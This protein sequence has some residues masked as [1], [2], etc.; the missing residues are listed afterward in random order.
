MNAVSLVPDDFRQL[1]AAVRGRVLVP[2]A[3]GYEEARRVVN[4]MIDRRPAAIVRCAGV[5]DIKSALAHGIDRN[6]PISIRCGGHSVPGFAVCEG[7]IMIDLSTMNSVR[8]DPAA[9]RARC[10]GGTNW[11]KFD[12]ETQAFG[13]ATTGG[14]VR[15]TGVAG[16]TL[17][18][19]HG[20]L[21]RKHGLACDNLVS[22][23]VLTASGDLLKASADENPDLFWAL[24]GGG[25]NFGIVTSFEFGLHQ[26]GL[27]YGGVLALPFDKAHQALRFF[28]TFNSSAPDH[29]GVLA[30]IATLPDGTKSVVHLVCHSGPSADAEAEVKPLR[31]NIQ[32][33][34]DQVGP[35]PYTALQSIVE[36]FNPHGMRNYWKTVYLND[37][38]DEAISTM[39][40]LYGRVPAPLTHIVLY[41]LG[42]AI[43]RVDADATAVS[44]RDARYA[45]IAIGMW[46]HA[47][48]D[49]VNIAWVREF[50]ERMQPF[51]SAGFYPNYDADAKPDQ[52][53][54]A[55]GEAK[56]ARLAEVK[57]KYDP[58]NVFRLN[59][60]IKP[61]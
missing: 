42:G 2:G 51:A 41:A 40:E 17:A 58:N 22:M 45:A 10:E 43:A 7:G 60:N 34:M 1:Q 21:A 44:H 8:V 47:A 61:A 18:G 30:A 50:A 28:D 11:G 38:T 19:G 46:D 29:L 12:Y 54:A 27:L 59:Q 36:N 53:K 4:G 13:L 32:P 26:V 48:D 15:T 39:T 55:F 56:Y 16:L 6:L 20:F 52:V 49:G 3:D 14:L 24:R 25:G 57:R 35:V 33:L 31:T 9:R 23:D 5:A 37:L